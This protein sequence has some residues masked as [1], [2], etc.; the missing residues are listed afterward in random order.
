M[1][2]RASLACLTFV[3]LGVSLGGLT[4][5]PPCLPCRPDKYN[6]SQLISFLQQLLSHGGYY[7]ENLEFIHVQRIQVLNC[8]VSCQ[9]FLFSKARLACILP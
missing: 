8:A 2:Y 6:T 1:Y 7:D 3:T 9:S 4:Q 5:L